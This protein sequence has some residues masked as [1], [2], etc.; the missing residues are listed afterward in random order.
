MLALPRTRLERK[1]AEVVAMLS[2]WQHRPDDNAFRQ[3]ADAFARRDRRKA[4]RL[5][6]TPAT[7]VYACFIRQVAQ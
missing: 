1:I 2:N 5:T 3:W 6:D 4:C 7:Y